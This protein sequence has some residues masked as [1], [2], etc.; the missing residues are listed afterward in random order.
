MRAS[1]HQCGETVPTL[2]RPG[3]G[4]GALLCS[5]PPPVR[6]LRNVRHGRMVS[7]CSGPA[8][9][10]LPWCIPR[11]LRVGSSRF[12]EPVSDSSDHVADPT[13]S[14]VDRSSARISMP[15]YRRRTRAAPAPGFLV[16]PSPTALAPCRQRAP[17]WAPDTTAFIARVS[18]SRGPRQYCTCRRQ[19]LSE[20][21]IHPPWPTPRCW[22]RLCSP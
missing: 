17:V 15:V 19:R 4:G 11:L 16:Y 10:A 2:F 6:E 20:G 14:G 9:A 21:R 3:D 18:R 13:F 12:E 7:V 22:S 1:L 5:R 8:V